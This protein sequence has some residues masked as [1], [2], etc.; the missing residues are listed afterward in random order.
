MNLRIKFPTVRE[1]TSELEIQETVIENRVMH[2]MTKQQSEHALGINIIDYQ[3]LQQSRRQDQT[4]L[5]KNLAIYVYQTALH[6][7]FS[8]ASLENQSHY[9]FKQ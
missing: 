4:F 5:R 1:I 9:N 7:R 3:N 8:V 6:A 2:C